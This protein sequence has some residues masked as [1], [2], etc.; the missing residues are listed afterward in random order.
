M[1]SP[2]M[3]WA[4]NVINPILDWVLQFA[5]KPVETVVCCKRHWPAWQ[6]RERGVGN[7]AK[8]VEQ[9][10][11]EAKGGQPLS[12]RAYSTRSVPRVNP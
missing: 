9:A 11:G 5:R 8:R 10:R 6:C 1:L 4:K 12:L 7:R 3:I 2:F